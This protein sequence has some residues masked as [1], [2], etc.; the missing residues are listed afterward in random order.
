MNNYE[1]FAAISKGNRR[2]FLSTLGLALGATAFPWSQIEA[3]LLDPSIQ[4]K[5]QGATIRVVFLYPPS[6]TFADNP[7]GWWSWP[8]NDYDAEGHQQKYT[9]VLREFEKKHNLKLKIDKKSVSGAKDTQKV[10]QQI[11]TNRPDGLLLIMFYNGSLSQANLLLKASEELNIPTVFFI[12]LGVKHGPVDHY[13]RPGVYFIQSLDNLKAI[14]LGL[15]M[16]NTRKH[17][18]QSRLLSITEAKNTSENTES[19]LGIKVRKVPFARYAEFFHQAD[20]NKKAHK[21]IKSLTDNAIEIRGVTTESLQN[22]MRAHFALKKLLQNEDAD[23]LA[24]NCLKRG[25]LKPCVSFSLLNDQLITA[26]CENDLPA[27]YTQ[28]LGQSLVRR[29]GFQ[30]NPCFETE[31]N[32]Y[33]A[34]HC[35]CP[36]KVYGPD[37]SQLKYLL[38]RFAHTNEGSCAIQ[39][40]WQKDDPVTM[41]HYY[42]GAKPKLDVY[43]GRVVQSHPMPPAA[44][45]TTN[46]EIEI[47]DRPDACMVKGHHNLLFC[48]DYARHFRLFAQLHRM[49]LSDSNYKGPWPI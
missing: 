3:G 34:S 38:R 40:F 43:A 36:T 33:Y 24:M 16:I 20:I 19:F 30:H 6:K 18:S 47:T 45:C 44:G 46:V 1:K 11:Q 28:M 41:V 8:G 22:A 2:D 13:R 21:L 17:L 14:E 23:G 15:R 27:A 35:T 5:K 25:M 48:G 32:H 9:K 4:R 39:A 7:D 49:E 12:G 26:T 37:G 29:P 42:P 10:I 31:K